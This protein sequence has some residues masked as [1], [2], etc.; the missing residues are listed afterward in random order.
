MASMASELS[1]LGKNATKNLGKAASDYTSKSY[2]SQQAGKQSGGQ[3][4]S[5]QAASGT[6]ADISKA[7]QQVGKRIKKYVSGKSD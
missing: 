4:K 1:S 6:N 5:K 3:S 7:A 2:G